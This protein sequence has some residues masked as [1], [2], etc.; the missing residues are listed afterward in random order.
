VN[1]DSR[2][3]FHSSITVYGGR[4]SDKWN[5]AAGPSLSEG[6]QPPEAHCRGLRSR[7]ETPTESRPHRV[8]FG[9]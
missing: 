5:G 2:K 6:G 8:K 7:R 3:V 1:L 4:G 9:F